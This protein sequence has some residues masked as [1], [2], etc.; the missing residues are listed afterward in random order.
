M[1]NQIDQ[2][3]EGPNDK[4]NTIDNTDNG[5]LREGWGLIPISALGV[6]VE[7]ADSP[8]TLGVSSGHTGL[9]PSPKTWLTAISKLCSM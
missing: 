4:Y 9:S 2:E 6:C 7:F 5:K 8:R 1:T 3:Q